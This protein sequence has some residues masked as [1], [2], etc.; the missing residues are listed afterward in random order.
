VA[1]LVRDGNLAAS[2]NLSLDPFFEENRPEEREGEYKN[3]MPRLIVDR[4]S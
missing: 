1:S 4:E 2:A 3:G